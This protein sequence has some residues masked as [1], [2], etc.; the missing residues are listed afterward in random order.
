MQIIGDVEHATHWLF[1]E[2]NHADILACD[3]QSD[4]AAMFGGFEDEGS[5]GLGS[6][7]G[8]NQMSTKGLLSAT[9]FS[10]LE[11]VSEDRNTRLFGE[12]EA[13]FL[14]ARKEN[15][16]ES[17][18]Q[19]ILATQNLE[20]ENHDDGEWGYDIDDDD[21]GF[22]SSSSHLTDVPVDLDRLKIQEPSVAEGKEE[23]QEELSSSQHGTADIEMADFPSI[24]VEPLY[25][26]NLFQRDLD[27]KK[28]FPHRILTLFSRVEDLSHILVWCR[29]SNENTT[30]KALD[31][32]FIELARLKIK[33]YPD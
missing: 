2:R 26:L 17:L 27:V 8:E 13:Q 21:G 12:I 22:S 31:V 28:K 3:L 30:P 4:P 15:N 33:F 5:F 20:E 19:V 25:L 1:D 32:A 18:E 14:N 16:S 24:S 7:G 9:G 10:L 23:A 6:S 29:S 11:D